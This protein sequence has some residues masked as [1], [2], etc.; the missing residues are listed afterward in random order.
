MAKIMTIILGIKITYSKPSLF[1]FRKTML[2]RGI[3]KDFVTVMVMLYL[4]TQLGNAKEVT[5]TAAKVLGHAPRTIQNY[6][7]DNQKYFK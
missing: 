1:K 4:I 5:D 3:K 6:I 7:F 2:E